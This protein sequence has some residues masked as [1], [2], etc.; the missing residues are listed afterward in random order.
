MLADI[1]EKFRDSCLKYYHIDPDNFVSAPSL[2][3]HAMLLL[4]D[5]IIEPYPTL[6]IYRMLQKAKHGGASQVTTRYVRAENSKSKKIRA[7]FN[8]TEFNEKY[9]NVIPYYLDCN[10]LYP[11]AML[12][13]LPVGGWKLISK[14]DK[15]DKWILSI[16]EKENRNIYLKRINMPL[17]AQG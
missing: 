7:Y 10:Q 1:F 5:V 11:I 15:D 3:Y 2:S 17:R 9:R 16:D 12:Y 4:S 14:Q 8:D 6:E 13:A